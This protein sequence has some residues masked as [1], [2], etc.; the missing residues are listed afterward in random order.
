M[1]AIRDALNAAKRRA[2]GAYFRVRTAASL[3]GWYAQR[4]R[5]G[6]SAAESPFDDDFWR[7]NEVGDWAGFARAVLRHAPA[8]SALDVGCGDGKLLAAMAAEAPGLRAVGVDSSGPALERARGRGVEVHA[9]D[10]AGTRAAGVDAFAQGLGR[11]DVA[12]SLE[13]VEH[14]PAWHSGKLLRLLA[15]CAPAIVFSGAQP[16]QGGVLHVN[17]RPVEHWVQRFGEMGFD[18]S[19]HNEAFRADV[20]ALDLPPW[21]AAN[22]N[23][24]VRRG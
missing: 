13:T 16:L 6:A 12:I 5:S 11:F 14:F 17:E 15:G 19:P 7:R 10:L 4:A 2:P 22:V 24:F 1:S 8:R 21:Y 23:L 9:L 18:L 3:L 20:R